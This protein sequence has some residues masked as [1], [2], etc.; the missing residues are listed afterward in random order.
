MAATVEELVATAMVVAVGAVVA[1]AVAI[2]VV[3]IVIYCNRYIIL[4]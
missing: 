1:A 2:E 3:V 4:L